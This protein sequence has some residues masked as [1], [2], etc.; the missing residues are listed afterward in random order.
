MSFMYLILLYIFRV[1]QNLKQERDQTFKNFK[2]EVY[3]YGI[4]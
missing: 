4:L 3:Q 2:D 1:T